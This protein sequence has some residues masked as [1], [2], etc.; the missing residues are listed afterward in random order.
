MSTAVGDLR[1]RLALLTEAFAAVTLAALTQ[2]GGL[3]TATT[4]TPHQ[5]TTGDFTDVA[6]AAVAGYNGRKKVTVTGPLS[7][8]FTVTS[9]LASPAGGT[10]TSTY[11]SDAQGGRRSSWNVVDTIPAQHVEYPRSPFETLVAGAV[12]STTIHQFRVRPRE[13]L[14]LP[15]RLRWTPS[16][17][18]DPRTLVLNR[19]DPISDGRQW[20]MLTASEVTS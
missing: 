4:A 17:G 10:V 14:R 3:A 12:Q 18:Q 16:W 2:A 1:E 5:L 13:D 15:M 6:G 8:T 11:W 20:S 7:F 9:G 19:V